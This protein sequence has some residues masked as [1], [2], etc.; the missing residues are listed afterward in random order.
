MTFSKKIVFRPFSLHWQLAPMH[1]NVIIFS[2][3]PFS[4]ATLS[5]SPFSIFEFQTSQ[6]D[7]RLIIYYEITFSVA[8]MRR[9]LALIAIGSFSVQPIGLRKM[10]FLSSAHF[11]DADQIFSFGFSCAKLGQK[12]IVKF[13]LKSECGRF[14]VERMNAIGLRFF[15]CQKRRSIQYRVHLQL[16]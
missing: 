14:A 13:P 16:P 5:W 15:A 7:L 10:A 6:I 1:R 8:S 9:T 4:A 2:L 12:N 3:H 11:R